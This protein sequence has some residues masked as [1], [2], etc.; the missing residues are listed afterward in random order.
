RCDQAAK[1]SLSGSLREKVSKK[2]TRTFKLG[3]VRASV[4]ANVSKDLAL[5]LSTSARNGLKAKKSE[6]L[7][8]TLT[9]TNANGKS[10]ATTTVSLKRG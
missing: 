10:T 8:L 5:K 3:P 2:R 4:N 1:V 9:A 6:S 7:K